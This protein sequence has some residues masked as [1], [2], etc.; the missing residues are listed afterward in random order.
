MYGP[1]VVK[2]DV[3]Y[4]AQKGHG[5]VGLSG[6]RGLV[7]WKEEGGEGAKAD[8]SAPLGRSCGPSPGIPPVPRSGRS[9]PLATGS[10]PT[11]SP[12]TSSRWVEDSSR[13]FP[14]S[15][16]SGADE[17]PAERRGPVERRESDQR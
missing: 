15:E 1:P 17:E 12:N 7:M 5:L 6:D 13:P 9:R 10:S 14:C 3:V 16:P 2:D 4:V 8:V 11:S